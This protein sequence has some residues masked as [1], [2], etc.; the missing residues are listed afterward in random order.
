MK[1]CC[2]GKAAHP[3]PRLGGLFFGTPTVEGRTLMK[4]CTSVV[5]LCLCSVAYAAWPTGF[6]Q[7][8]QLQ[9]AGPVP[10]TGLAFTRLAQGVQLRFNG[11]AKNVVFYG[12][13]TVRVNTNRGQSFA[14]NSSL[15]VVADPVA[16]QFELHESDDILTLVSSKL[17]I[18]VDK[19][20]GAITFQR[21]DGVPIARER[22]EA[23]EIEQVTIAGA[24]TYA[25]KQ[26][27]ALAPEESLY[28]LGQYNRPYMDYRGQEVLMVQT[29]IGI[30]VPFLLSTKRYGILWDSYSK[31][32][33]KDSAEGASFWSESAPAGV[34]L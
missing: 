31:S 19:K 13:T 1:A 14:A 6:D 10:A 11:L 26:T 28:G 20:S 30:V 21:P 12:P 18:H 7:V 25:V 33:F 3:Y 27:F 15:A 24:P 23:P 16:V 2:S 9:Q 17:R 5:M 8:G 29:N 4:L 34:D 32:V 22:T